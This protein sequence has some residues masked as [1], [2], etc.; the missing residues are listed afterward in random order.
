[1]ASLRGRA[2]SE[3]ERAAGFKDGALSFLGRLEKAQPVRVCYNACDLPPMAVE[4]AAQ[5]GA[6]HNHGHRLSRWF[7][8]AL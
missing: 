5:G 6:W 2:I 4:G 8:E 3:W 1:M 7:D